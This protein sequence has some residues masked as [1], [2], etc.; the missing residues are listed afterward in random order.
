M[1]LSNSLAH[2]FEEYISECEFSKQLRPQ[3][4]KSYRDVFNTFCTI[5]PEIKNSSD[6][7]IYVFHEFFKRLSTRKRKVGQI[8]IQTGVKPSTIRTYYNKLIAFFHWLEEKGYLDNTFCSKLSK[9]PKPEY[10]DEK[11]LSE[12][13]ISKIISAITQHTFGQPFLQQR[14]LLIINLLLY[15]GVRKGELLA[16]K[17]SD[18]DFQNKK[19]RIKGETS[20]SK[21][22][23]F[24]P[25]HIKLL[26]QLKYYIQT[27]QKLGYINHYLICSSRFDQQLSTHGLKHWVKKYNR[28]SSVSFHIHQFRHTFACS[29]AKNKADMISIMKV[30]GHRT[31]AMTQRYLRSIQIEDS[32][33]FINDL[34]F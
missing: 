18:I 27:R 10:N 34:N 9:P 11:A 23:R 16:I 12:S 13:N 30:L 2:Y 29:L 25:L 14:D 32:R 3:T 24:I 7:K 1:L 5:M 6:L 20:K 17:L 31:I 33:R 21:R 28:L 8:H 15:T 19:L 26:T 4:I 22:D